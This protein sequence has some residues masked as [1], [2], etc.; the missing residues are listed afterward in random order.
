MYL[1]PPPQSP[2]PLTHLIDTGGATLDDGAKGFPEA[3]GPGSPP[4]PHSQPVLPACPR[5]HPLPLHPNL[6]LMRHAGHC[7]RCCAGYPFPFVSFCLFYVL[8][9]LFSY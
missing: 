6:D 9:C 5:G 3:Q 4:Q 1:P 2:I 7:V 8:F